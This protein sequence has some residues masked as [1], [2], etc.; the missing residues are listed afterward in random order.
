MNRRNKKTLVVVGIIA[1]GMLH[2]TTFMITN[3]RPDFTEGDVLAYDIESRLLFWSKKKNVTVFAIYACCRSKLS[4][5]QNC[6][7][8]GESAQPQRDALGNNSLPEVQP[9]ASNNYYAVFGSQQSK[10]MDV[11]SDLIP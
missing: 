5:E 7:L 6:F 1:H 8:L 9:P 4:H 10:G 2:G 11:D 3:P